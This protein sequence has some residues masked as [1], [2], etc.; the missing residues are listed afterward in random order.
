[1]LSSTQVFRSGT[2]SGPTQQAAFPSTAVPMHRNVE[3]SRPPSIGRRAIVFPTLRRR[4][5]MSF[6]PTA[7]TGRLGVFVLFCVVPMLFSAAHARALP[8][9]ITTESLSGATAGAPY[10]DAIVAA[11][12]TTP[13]T[14]SILSGS[15]PGG[16]TLDAGTGALSGTATIAETTP[17]IVK[18]EDAVGDTAT[19]ALAITVT[20]GAA[21]TLAF[22]Q[23]P[24]GAIVGQTLAPAIAL[25]LADAYD[26]AV[27]AEPVTL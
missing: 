20:P 26:N 13:Y 5:M 18:V 21:A 9:E 23:Q 22:V 14:W 10:S 19:R 3:R 27:P 7:A 16:I 6:S 1:M 8:L 11:N 15:L 17:F 25:R 24:T 2:K 4:E 12:G